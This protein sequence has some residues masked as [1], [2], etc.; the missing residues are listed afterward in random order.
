MSQNTTIRKLA[1]LVNKPV[2]T[3]LVQLAEAGMPFDS[4]DQ[5]VSSD[6]KTKLLAYL[7][8][9]HGRGEA[10]GGANVAPTKN[11]LSSRK[12]EEIKDG[13]GKNKSTVGVVVRKKIQ[14]GP[15]AEAKAAGPVSDEQAEIQRKLD[16]S[17]Q[18]NL[19][20]QQRLA[21]M[22][23]ERREAKMAEEAKLEEAKA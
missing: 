18:R 19:E 2:E 20:E 10:S 11:T 21:E 22:D 1:E 9:T 23:R 14:L 17:R 3:L 15:T 4:A 7:K 12:E 16:E 5:E 8:K 6:Q 13:G